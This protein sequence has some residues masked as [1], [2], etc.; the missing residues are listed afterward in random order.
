MAADRIGHPTDD[1]CMIQARIMFFRRCLRQE[2]ILS[3]AGAALGLAGAVLFLASMDAIAVRDVLSGINWWLVLPTLLLGC[4][5]FWLRTLRW[6]VLLGPKANLRTS[7]L[8][9]IG[10]TAGLIGLILPARGGDVVKLALAS[11]LPQI[12]VAQVAAAELLERLV[13][14]V[15]L[16]SFITG[17]AMA[18]GD[19]NWLLFFGLLALAVHGPIFAALPLAGRM[20][21]DD[22]TSGSG[23]RIKRLILQAIEAVRQTDRARIVRAI[24]LSVLAWCAQA[25]ACYLL[26]MAFGW[27]ASPALS[28]ATVGVTNFA[29]GVPG[30]PAGL[31]TVEFPMRHLMDHFGAEPGLASA[32]PIAMHLS[33]LAPLPF[34]WALMSLYRLRFSPSRISVRRR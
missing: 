26:L 11:R 32:Y 31:G 23:S 15:V 21:Y 13:D 6:G 7:Q 34:L 4:V 2:Y 30:A 1:C 5:N 9:G 3:V 8:A 17:S 28:L 22:K 16:G 29:F 12:S 33:I 25:V 20:K 19:S 14:G 24:K 10:L 18:T 27:L